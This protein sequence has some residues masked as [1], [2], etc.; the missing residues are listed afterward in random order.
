MRIK[1]HYYTGYQSNTKIHLRSDKIKAAA[2]RNPPVPPYPTETDCTVRRRFPFLR[3]NSR[4]YKNRFCKKNY[5]Q[6]NKTTSY[7]VG[8]YSSSGN[9]PLVYA[10]S[11]QVFPTKPSPTTVIFAFFLLIVTA[12][13]VKGGILMRSSE[14]SRQNCKYACYYLSIAILVRSR[15]F[16][17][18]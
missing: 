13:M 3:R 18:I 9:S 8:M 16:T 11:R 1:L 12:T 14:R 4:T 7:T 17:A 5:K 6:R 15:K 2:F 10:T